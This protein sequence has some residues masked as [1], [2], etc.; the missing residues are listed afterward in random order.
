[1]RVQVELYP[2]KLAKVTLL[3]SW[4][5]LSA[6]VIGVLLVIAV[7]VRLQVGGIVIIFGLV[8][9]PWIMMTTGGLMQQIKQAR[10]SISRP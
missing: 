10:R 5:Y 7:L 6:L 2:P 4:A 9:L 1:M 3:R 8:T